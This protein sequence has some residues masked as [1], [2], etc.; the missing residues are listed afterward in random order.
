MNDSADGITM[1]REVRATF[2]TPA[3]MQDAVGKLSMSGFDRADLGLPSPGLIQGTE[4]PEAG[5]KPAATEADARQ[6]RTLGASTA[7]AAAGIAAA[8]VTVATGGAAAPAVAAAVVAGGAAGGSVFAVHKAADQSEQ[9]DRQARA[10]SG[11]LVL[12]VR[13]TTEA[14]RSEAEAILRAAGATNI[15]V[16]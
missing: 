7:A 6:A 11:D 15:E 2:A 5:T 9:T 12:G 1:V 13:A 16:I 4:T 14:K 3:Q 10:A 8:G